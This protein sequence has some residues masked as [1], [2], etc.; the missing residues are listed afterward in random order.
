MHA[1]AR[2]YLTLTWPLKTL[3]GNVYIS[4]SLSLYASHLIKREQNPKNQSTHE[5]RPDNEVIVDP[6]IWRHKWNPH[7]ESSVVGVR[8]GTRGGGKATRLCT[9]DER[10]SKDLFKAFLV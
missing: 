1:A 8:L 4:P 2:I 7:R 10:S 9:R 6:W 5:V 3:S